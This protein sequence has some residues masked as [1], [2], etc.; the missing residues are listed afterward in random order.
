MVTRFSLLALI[1]CF[2]HIQASS[3]TVG[4]ITATSTVTGNDLSI[5]LTNDEFTC[6]APL[7]FDET[8]FDFIMNNSS[9]LFYIFSINDEVM[10]VGSLLL[11]DLPS[12]IQTNA[13]SIDETGTMEMK[14]SV[15]FDEDFVN[16]ADTYSGYGELFAITGFTTMVPLIFV[17][18]LALTI[19][20]VYISLFCAVWIGS[21]II[22]GCSFRASYEMALGTYILESAAS[23]DHQFVILFTVFLSGLVFLIQRSG[24]TQGFAQIL[25]KLAKTGKRT[26]FACFF[27]GLLL[28]FDD[29]ANALVV[30]TTF[31][32]LTDYFH[33][34]RY[35]IAYNLY[36]QMHVLIPN[37]S[38]K[39]AF[40]VDATSAPVAS[41]VPLS[42]WIGFEL[43]QIQEQ[44]DAI[45]NN[46]NDVMPDGLTDNAFVFFVETIPTRF[47][48]IYM[49]VFQV[50]IMSL[51]IEFGPMLIAERKVAVNK[52]DDG[53]DG[54]AKTGGKDGEQSAV[55][56]A[57]DTPTRWWNMLVPLTVLVILILAVIIN[58]GVEGVEADGEEMSARN[59]FAYSDPWGSLLYGT[60]GASMF[61]IALF[62]IQFKHKGAI[63]LPSLT[64]CKNCLFSKKTEND[65][66]KQEDEIICAGGDD[67]TEDKEKKTEKDFPV[68]LIRFT[69]AIETWIDGITFMC[70]AVCIL[71]LVWAIGAIMTDIG[72]DRYFTRII[73]EDVAASNL[74]TL[75]FILAA[76][77]SAAIG[78][79]WG[80]MTIMFP[81]VSPA[82]WTI[83]QDLDNGPWLYTVTMSQIL[84]G[85][86]FGDHSSPLSDT[87]LLSSVA[88][89]CDLF[90]HVYTQIGYAVW[91]SFFSVI[92]GT[93][94]A[95]RGINAGICLF[96]GIIVQLIFTW[97]VGAPVLAKNGR[98]DVFTELYL[99]CKQKCKCL[100]KKAVADESSL[101]GLKRQTIEFVKR[102]ERENVDLLVEFLKWSR[103][104]IVCKKC[105][106]DL[107]EDD[108]EKAKYD[109]VQLTTTH[110]T[111]KAT[112][113]VEQETETDAEQVDNAKVTDAE[114]IDLL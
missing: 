35:I 3:I 53:G 67:E 102:E 34:S 16:A 15:S 47:Y 93:L 11:D 28:F 44:L 39:L 31:K 81:L 72:A 1:L 62:M 87:T 46:N 80:T 78:S 97:L 70:P 92:C 77:L 59:I 100:E 111:N 99:F 94:M 9:S 45:K 55:K 98:F 13:V 110:E 57:K 40:L 107:D 30:G 17:I 52:R 64:A 6:S 20:N 85:S 42:S 76:L 38:E 109:K 82:A 10:D 2:A 23:I 91:V 105:G 65:A 51:S 101:I 19:K 86:I 22:S 58:S 21:F 25:S 18:F 88:S 8:Q 74:P 79:S 32:P 50:I 48:P 84:S 83:C 24:G 71:I 68:P 49:L 60:F 54:K 73:S 104:A 75:V 29:Y 113:V 37:Y 43:Q 95:G 56:P 103:F 61:T 106:V 89:G 112:N 26:Q 14:L 63:V 114:D 108:T 33:I 7:E 66:D 90:K 27:L 69:E 5:L 96:V 12:S 36:V 4:D 41:M